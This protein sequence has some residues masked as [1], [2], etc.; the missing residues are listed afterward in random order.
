MPLLR[1]WRGFF[2]L[3][4]AYIPLGFEV[5]MSLMSARVAYI[6]LNNQRYFDDNE[7]AFAAMTAYIPQEWKWG[8]L[9]AMAC[10]FK[11][12]GFLGFFARTENGVETAFVLR[13]AGW[14]MSAV[15]WCSLG[16]TL[17][18]W[19]PGKITAC[20]TLM[21]GIFSVGMVLAGPVMP[22]QARGR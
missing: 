8:T 3:M 16:A 2:L 4:R 18:S 14:A 9:A 6:L 20:A 17:L 21:L 22:E 11:L 13:A 15:L 5:G 12:A 10:A 7:H 1:R 19:N